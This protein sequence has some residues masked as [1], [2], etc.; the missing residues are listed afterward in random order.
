MKRNFL[1]LKRFEMLCFKYCFKY[2]FKIFKLTLTEFKIL[3][4]LLKSRGN[5]L[6][7]DQLRE[8]AL[9]KI[10]VSDRTIDV[11]MASLRK[12]ISNYAS[13]IKTVRGVGYR[14]EE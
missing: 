7:R 3:C 10:N 8:M 2:F 5:V 4:E 14:F 6:S 11:H 12:K 1:N 9:G 13:W